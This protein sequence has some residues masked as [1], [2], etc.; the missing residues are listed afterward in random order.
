MM[1]S[2][3]RATRGH[4]A[5]KARAAMMLFILMVGIPTIWFGG[6]ISVDYSR[7]L[8]ANRQAGQLADAASLAGALQLQSGDWRIDTRYLDVNRAHDTAQELIQRAQ[9]IGAANR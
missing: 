2:H 9:T 4:R 7:V 1:R 8:S 6:A 5:R 3:V